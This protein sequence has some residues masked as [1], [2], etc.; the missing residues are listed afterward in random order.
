VGRGPTSAPF[1]LDIADVTVNKLRHDS[2]GAKLGQPPLF[3]KVSLHRFPSAVP[4]VVV[5]P[6]LCHQFAIPAECEA[7]GATLA[8]L[9]ADLDRQYPGVRHYLLDDQG[10]LRQHVNLFVNSAW[11]VD[12]QRLSDAVAPGDQVHILQALSGG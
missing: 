12:R 9:V 5:A 8:D 6:H 3:A 10:R 2:P 4:H 11:I 1:S 7:A